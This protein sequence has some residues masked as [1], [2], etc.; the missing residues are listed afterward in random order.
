MQNDALTLPSGEVVTANSL[1]PV[2]G[3]ARVDLVVSQIPG[4]INNYPGAVVVCLT[5]AS[6]GTGTGAWDD[7][8]SA[9][10]EFDLWAGNRH[11]GSV[12]AMIGHPGGASGIT[13]ANVADSVGALGR[14][15]TFEIDRPTSEQYKFS[16]LDSSGKSMG[17]G[18]LSAASFLEALHIDLHT[19]GATTATFDNVTIIPEPSTLALLGIG[20]IGLL[21]W[22]LRR[23]KANRILVC[24]IAMF[25][26]TAGIASADVF[27][28]GGTRDPATGTWTGQASL[29][30]VTVGDAGNAGDTTQM[31][32]DGT[33]GYGA[34]AYTY[35]ICKY[36]VTTAQYTAFLNAVAATDTY[37]LYNTNMASGYYAAC[38]ISRSGSPGSYAYS[39][40]QGRQLP[41]E[42]HFLGRRGPI[43]QLAVKRPTDGSPR[44]PARPRLARTP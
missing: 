6:A 22:A 31:W 14:K 42:Q 8:L 41:G 24:F 19:D 3:G 23:R 43:L 16:V 34:I 35:S 21:A 15:F 33:T 10:L 9:K 39:D 18:L 30:F 44:P 32:L 38:G 4:I 1:V 17:S 26:S 27:N 20:A 7:S 12:L 28:M 2:G 36:D 5:T 37:D 11:P 29:E 25:A 40:D 13:I